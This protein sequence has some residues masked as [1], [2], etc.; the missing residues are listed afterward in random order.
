MNINLFA[1][2]AVLSLPMM[3]SDDDDVS[4]LGVSAYYQLHGFTCGFTSALMVARY[5]N[6]RKSN[7]NIYD[8]IGTNEEGTE[9][10]RLIN[11]LRKLGLRVS[12]KK[13]L[14]FELVKKSIDNGFPIITGSPKEN[15]YIVIFGYG[16]NPWR[17]F[18]ADPRLKSVINSPKTLGREYCWSVFRKRRYGTD[19][20]NMVISKSRKKS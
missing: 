16:E 4:I 7:E 12:Q 14:T 10:Y 18:V 20:S 15:H 13:S 3:H 2:H 8:I 5:F 11:G 1:K 6:C 9:C 17:V 19:G